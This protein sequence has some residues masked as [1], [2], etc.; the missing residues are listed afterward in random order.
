M[1]DQYKSPFLIYQDFLTS[2]ECDHIA[3]MVKIETFK[4]DEGNLI[5]SERH[6]EGAEKEVFQKFQ[7]LTHE[8]EEY[9]TGFQ[10]RGTEHLIFQQFPVSNGKLSEEPHC[11]NSVYK[12]KKWI[13]VVDRELT[14]ILWLKDY[15]EN[16][17]F[18]VNTQVLGGKLEFPVYNFGFQPQ[19]GTLIIYPACPRFISLTSPVLVGELQTVRFHICGKQSW[20]YQPEN[21]P[22]DL[23]T[24]FNH[25]V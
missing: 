17:P 4:D 24:W 5:P 3:N 25:V 23:R 1:T 2:E 18:D 10:Y 7:E 11:E 12:R 22:G 15:K 20:I 9:F 8:I 16:P 6:H 19:K 13:K 14:A 21:F